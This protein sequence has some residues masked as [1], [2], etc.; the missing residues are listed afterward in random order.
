[1]TGIPPL[2]GWLA[3]TSGSPVAALALGAVLFALVLPATATL[4]WLRRGRP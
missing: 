4:G 3:D 1:M 2:A